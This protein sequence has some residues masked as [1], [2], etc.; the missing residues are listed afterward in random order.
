[1][2]PTTGHLVDMTDSAALPNAW[3][4]VMCLGTLIFALMVPTLAIALCVTKLPGRRVDDG[5]G[6]GS[7]SLHDEFWEFI[8]AVERGDVSLA[9]VGSAAEPD[10]TSRI[11]EKPSPDGPRRVAG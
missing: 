1:M 10:N 2:N 7:V 3:E 6:L 5:I 8:T 11:A 4:L 9:S